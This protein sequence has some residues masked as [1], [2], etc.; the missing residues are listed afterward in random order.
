MPNYLKVFCVRM[1]HA[2]LPCKAMAGGLRG[3]A[4]AEARCDACVN[5]PP[6][7]S[8][9]RTETYTHLFLECHAYR[10]ALTWLLDLWEA[11]GGSRPPVTAAVLVADDVAAW[12]SRPGDRSTP[13]AALWQHLRLTVLY[14][15]W[16]A[17]CSRDSRCRNGAAVV[18]HAVRLLREEMHTQWLRSRAPGL[19]ENA[20]PSRIM[21]TPRTL[22]KEDSLA[23][24]QQAGLCTATVPAAAG[25]GAGSGGAGSPS[26]PTL[27]IHLTAAYPVAA[28][29]DPAN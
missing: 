7:D 25:G 28:P 27:D 15:I 3:W 16:D 14:C 11:I 29:A 8:A 1:M 20:M 12:S 5:H 23:M 4:K 6:G 13:S 24:W 21:R 9:D 17:R 10:P 26:D 18:R 2:A 22:P 19:W